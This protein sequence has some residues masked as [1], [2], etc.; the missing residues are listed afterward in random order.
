MERGNKMSVPLTSGLSVELQIR[1][2]DVKY[3]LLLYFY[4]TDSAMGCHDRQHTI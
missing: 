3:G 4:F 1:V 2:I